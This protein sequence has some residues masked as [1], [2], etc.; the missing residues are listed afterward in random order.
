M[1]QLAGQPFTTGVL[2]YFDEDPDKKRENAAIYIPVNI[3]LGGGRSIAVIAF[4]DT[5]SPYVMVGPDVIEAL[6]L[7]PHSAAVHI[8]VHTRMG[9][10]DGFLDSVD[11]V[12][13][14]EDGESLQIAA[15]VFASD[16]WDQGVFLGYAGCMTHFNFAVQPDANKFFFGAP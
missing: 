7:R 6:G 12:I 13:P 16:K 9:L 2:T 14:A 8:T 4:V 5:G 1:L 3:P 10:I 11:L 15:N